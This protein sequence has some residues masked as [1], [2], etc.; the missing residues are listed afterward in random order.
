MLAVFRKTEYDET[1]QEAIS[2]SGKRKRRTGMKQ[3]TAQEFERRLDS[4]IDELKRLYRELY[5]GD[6]QA[7]AYFLDM[8]RRAYD[9]RGEALRE[10]DRKRE[11]DPEWYKR[12][13]IT[14]MLLYVNAFAKTLKGTEQK[15]DYL[16][17]CGV[18]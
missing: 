12:R 16:E 5:H 1:I 18:N 11:A 7:F 4:R 6:E 10:L 14:G 8:L 15:L 13:D 2:E 9:E 17:D 3:R